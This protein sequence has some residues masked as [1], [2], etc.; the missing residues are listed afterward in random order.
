[1]EARGALVGLTRGAHRAHVVRAAL[2]SM[3]YQTRDVLEVMDRDA[4]VLIRELRVDGGAAAN[5]FLMQF[6]ADLLGIPV[7]RPALVETTA[8]GAAYLAGLAVGF[9][10]DP[11]ELSTARRT[12]RTFAP[13]MDDARRR[14]LYGGWKAAVRMTLSAR[15]AREGSGRT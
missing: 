1:M 4:G 13:A 2:E 15:G 8:A 10:R 7:E 9:W 11:G 3:A 14:E 5:G 12:E 6:Q